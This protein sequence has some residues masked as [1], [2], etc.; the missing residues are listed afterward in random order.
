MAL[1]LADVR[2]LATPAITAPPKVG[3]TWRINM[4]RMD[5]PAGKPQQASGWSPPLVGDFHALDKF[6]ELV[7][8]DEKGQLPAGRRGACR[9]RPRPIRTPMLQKALNAGLN[10]DREPTR[11]RPPRRRG[12]KPIRENELAWRGSHYLLRAAGT[13]TLRLTLSPA[14]RV[15]LAQPRSLSPASALAVPAPGSPPS[16]R[17]AQ[18]FARRREPGAGRA[19]RKPRPPRRPPMRSTPRRSRAADGLRVQLPGAC[20]PAGPGRQGLG[21]LESGAAEGGRRRGH[22]GRACR[23]RC[24]I[25]G[26]TS[27]AADLARSS[28]GMKPPPSDVVRFL[29]NHQG[30]DRA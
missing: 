12:K 14:L 7:F 2:G 17:R 19:V 20:R 21:E 29:A 27:V 23:R 30:V 4:F 15:F 5:M 16:V 11:S 3:D 13:T 9:R 10:D 6:G 22:R 25:R 8:G 1:P 28:R 26:C 24:P 18:R